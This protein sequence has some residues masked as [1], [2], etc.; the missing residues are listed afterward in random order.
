MRAT[1]VD[2]FSVLDQRGLLKASLYSGDSQVHSAPLYGSTIPGRYV[3]VGLVIS[4]RHSSSHSGGYQNMVNDLTI[5]IL[6]E[7]LI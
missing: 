4:L 3:C 7:F 2:L 1:R 6:Y 5:S